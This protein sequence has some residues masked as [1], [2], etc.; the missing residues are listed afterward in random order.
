MY[1]DDR[2]LWLEAQPQAYVLA[3][4]GRGYIWLGWQQRQAKTLNLLGWSWGTSIMGTYAAANP[5]QVDRL[6]L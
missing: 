4:S 3:V 1:G 6:V 2:R 5:G